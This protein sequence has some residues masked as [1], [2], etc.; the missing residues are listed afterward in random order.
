[1]VTHALYERSRFTGNALGN[2]AWSSM[3]ASSKISVMPPRTEAMSS[4]SIARCTLCVPITTSTYGAFSR[5][6]SLSFWAK[7]PATTIWRSRPRD[8]PASFH[9][10]NQPSV[11]YNF[12]SAFSRIQQVF[13]TTTSASSSCSAIS[14]PSCSSNPEIRSESCAFI[15][16]PKVRTTYLRV[17]VGQ[18]YRRKK[19][20]PRR[21]ARRH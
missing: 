1:M 7:Q 14:M 2:K 16:H 4:N 3:T 19:W 10:F 15:W 21:P 13:N 17:T 20:Q 12:S 8:L 9:G 11:P 5:T 6:T 18:V